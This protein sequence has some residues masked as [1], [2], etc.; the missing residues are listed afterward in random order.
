ME[1]VEWEVER[2]VKEDNIIYM[3]EVSAALVYHP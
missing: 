3:Y 2:R 1:V